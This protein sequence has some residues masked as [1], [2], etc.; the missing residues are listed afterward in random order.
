VFVW[1]KVNE[2]V[3]GGYGLSHATLRVSKDPQLGTVD[4]TVNDPAFEPDG[5]SHGGGI[6]LR[7]EDAMWLANALLLA[8]GKKKAFTYTRHS[9]DRGARIGTE[10]H[11]AAK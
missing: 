5:K 8:L 10:L 9:R 4:I 7:R 11:G 2:R 1:A 3:Y 6:T